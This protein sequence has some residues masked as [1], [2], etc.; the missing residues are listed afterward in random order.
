M[1]PIKLAAIRSQSV[2]QVAQPLDITPC[3]HEKQ[4]HDLL[5]TV[6]DSTLLCNPGTE[7]CGNITVLKHSRHWPAAVSR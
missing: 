6:W 1:N 5:T 4:A 3:G 2:V 7:Q